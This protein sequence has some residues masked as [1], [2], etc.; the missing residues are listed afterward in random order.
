[1]KRKDNLFR[2]IILTILLIFVSIIFIFLCWTGFTYK[3]EDRANNAMISD[4]IVEVKNEKWIS[5]TPVNSDVKYGFILY[6]GAKVEPEAYAPIC[7]K[8]ANNG[9]QVVIAK[10][11][12]NLAIFSPNIAQNIIESY[13]SVDSWIIG[14]HSLGGV[15]ASKFANNNDKIK[16]IVFLASYPSGD[17]LK[18]SDKQVVSLYGTE[19]GVINNKNLEESKNNLP[20]DTKFI[21]ID[22]GNHSQFGDY[23][24]Q[25]KDREARIS[26]EEQSN[27]TVQVILDLINNIK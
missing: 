15:M 6:P 9:V 5:F 4:S 16:G 1:M 21:E 23:G 13:E 22:G 20:N 18:Y 3:P 26:E 11:P 10:M 19:D 8:L 25:N 17:E 7:R 12:C 27:I 2:N 14:G 24:I